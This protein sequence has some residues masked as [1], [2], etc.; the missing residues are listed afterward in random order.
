MRRV[1]L[2]SS[3]TQNCPHCALL[4]RLATFRWTANG[5]D[6]RKLGIYIAFEGG[7]L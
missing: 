3:V 5:T 7:I 4:Q 1:R 2:L 6:N